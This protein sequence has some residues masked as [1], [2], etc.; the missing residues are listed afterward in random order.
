MRATVCYSS[1]ISI[2]MLSVRF[3][4]QRVF[5]NIPSVDHVLPKTL[6]A[7]NRRREQAVAM[8]ASWDLG[9][10]CAAAAMAAMATARVSGG[11]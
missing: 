7:G 6:H 5:L 11:D 9:A 10:A 4:L 8:A 3:K 2:S 1:A